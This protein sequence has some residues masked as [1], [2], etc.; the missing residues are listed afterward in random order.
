MFETWAS[1]VSEPGVCGA[2]GNRIF[3]AT[4]R[5]TSSDCG[6]VLKKEEAAAASPWKHSHVSYSLWK[7]HSK[8]MYSG[9]INNSSV[10]Q[11]VW[12]YA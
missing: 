6:S 10:F 1:S 12:M 11:G 9:G 7:W 4:Q 2:C 3:L 8:V 5:G